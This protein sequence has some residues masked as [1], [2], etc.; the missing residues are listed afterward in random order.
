[1]SKRSPKANAEL[2]PITLTEGIEVDYC[3]VTKGIWFDPGEL[4]EMTDLKEDLPEIGESI[5]AAT[6]TNYKSP[7]GKGY[8]WEMK[9]HPK[10]DVLIDFCK[11]SGGIWL[12]KGELEKLEKI[13]AGLESP[14]SKVMRAMQHFQKHGYQILSVKTQPKR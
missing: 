9:F 6:K 1:M 8:L 2:I 13:S 12:D 14:A 10:H 7:D 3:P 11:E 4:S 5:K